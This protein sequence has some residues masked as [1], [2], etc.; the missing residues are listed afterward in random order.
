M[1]LS[2]VTAHI[3]NLSTNEIT[4]IVNASKSATMGTE[5]VIVMEVP[6]VSLGDTTVY[7]IEPQP[8]RIIDMGG[9]KRME[10]L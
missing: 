9:Y 4:F 1:I 10:Y 3:Y 6:A 2:S 7:A 8:T 5:S